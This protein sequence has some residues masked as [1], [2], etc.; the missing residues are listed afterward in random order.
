[1]SNFVRYVVST[2]FSFGVAAAW[3]HGAV[4]AYWPQFRGPDRSA[5][6]QS[7]GLLTEWPEDGPPLVWQTD[8]A[9]RGYSSFSIAG[10]RLYTM[11][12]APSAATDEDEYLLCFDLTGGKLLWKAHLGA[13]WNEGPS[14]WQSSRSTPTV[15]GKRV[16]ALTA[17]GDLV[18]VTTSNG[19]E[20][21]RK[22]LLEDLEGNKGD[23]WGYSESVT[24]DGRL[25]ICTPGGEKN[26]MVA[27]NKLTGQMIWSASR[28]GERGAGHASIIISHV[29]GIRVYVQTTATG[30]LGV[31]AKDGKLMWS[32]E[33][34]EASVVIPT[35]IIR[36]NLVF[37]T[38]GY[39][40]GGTLLRQIPTGQGE[41]DIHEIYPLNPKLANKHGG[42]VLIGNA[43]YGDSGDSGTPF[44]ADLMTGEVLWKERGSGRGSAAFVAANGHL[45]IQFSNS[46]MVL[47]KATQEGYEEVSSFEI[48]GGSDRPSWAHPVVAGGRLYVRA[49][50][51]I[52]C[53]ELRVN[54]Q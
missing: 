21:W 42:V 11:G 15:D 5:I 37:F 30:A 41:V 12:D 26:T 40:R 19:R 54:A 4:T 44:C 24:V 31:R 53:Y 38:V 39:G 52:S 3:S 28:E 45:Y 47:V 27:L 50:D 1:M 6:S 23:D 32:Y 48:Q 17:H 10:G 8:E 49:D 25:L 9:G 2:L 46:V 35:P 18:C 36:D 34:E 22:N 14:D 29:G 33:I 7:K 43:I 51:T 16:Y 13:A 20:L